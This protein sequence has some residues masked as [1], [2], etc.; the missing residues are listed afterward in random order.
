MILFNK[1]VSVKEN[2]ENKKMSVREN[3]EKKVPVAFRFQCVF[4][5]IKMTIICSCIHGVGG[6]GSLKEVTT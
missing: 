4:A 6:S 3:V 5:Y 2:V 1:R